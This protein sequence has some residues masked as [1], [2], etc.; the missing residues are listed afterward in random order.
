L[1]IITINQSVLERFYIAFSAGLI[2][3]FG[4][5]P[6]ANKLSIEFNIRNT[7]SGSISRETARKWINGQ[8]LPSSQRLKTLI[9]W[10]DMDASFI[11]ATNFSEDVQPHL[12]SVNQKDLGKLEAY[13]LRKK[14]GLGRAALNYVSPLTAV[15]DK[16]GIIILVNSAWRSV[17]MAYPKLERGILVCEGINY[18]TVCDNAGKTSEEASKVAKCIREV[19]LDNKKEFNIQYPCHSNVKKNWFEV[20]ISAFKLQNDVC[21]IITHS[22]ITETIYKLHNK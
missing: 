17:A 20:K 22:P 14:E 6:T 21:Y 9:N 2:N 8:S 16:D 18:L 10:L 15:L 4:E 7:H 1:E 12:K 11:Y 13:S 19:I 3:R 5:K